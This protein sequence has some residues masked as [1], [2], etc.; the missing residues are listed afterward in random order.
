[1]AGR[2]VAAVGDIAPDGDRSVRDDQQ[3]AEDHV[4]FRHAPQATRRRRRPG[5][6][7][8]PQRR[9]PRSIAMSTPTIGSP[10]PG[11]S[12]ESDTG[13]RV[14]L[15][16]LRGRPVVLYF[17]PKDDTPGCTRQAS[18]IRDNWGEFGAPGSRCIGVSPGHD[19]VA[20]P[21]QAE[22]RAA[23]PAAGRPRPFDG[24]GVRHLGGEEELRQDVHGHR[25]LGVR[26]RRRRQPGAA[27][28]RIKPEDTASWA[29]GEVARLATPPGREPPGA[30]R[31]DP[32]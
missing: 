23:L 24:R 12:R 18:S 14:S 13:E 21:V 7:A 30:D 16:S 28:R 29:L 5:Y 20:R 17:Y 27:K 3:N 1:M 32:P 22:V 15:E 25:A 8:L 4:D 11:F 6:T 9:E 26:D 2:R 31:I 10:A 19:R